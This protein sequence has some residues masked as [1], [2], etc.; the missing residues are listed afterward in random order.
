[1]YTVKITIN[2]ITYFTNFKQ[3]KKFWLLLLNFTWVVILL[4][5]NLLII[6]YSILINFYLY[7]FVPTLSIY[8]GRLKTLRSTPTL[9][10]DNYSLLMLFAL[11]MN[12]K[13]LNSC[14]I[15]QFRSPFIFSVIKIYCKWSITQQV[16]GIISA[17]KLIVTFLAFYLSVYASR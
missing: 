2:K 10:Q 6:T 14:D 4:T 16:R 8:H 12:K 11:G 17:T 5:L 13:I 1:M 9:N 7:F 15:W 3:V